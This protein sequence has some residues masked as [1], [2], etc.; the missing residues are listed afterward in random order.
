MKALMYVSNCILPLLFFLVIGA[1]L[2]RRVAVYDEF[3]KGA[4]EGFT[5]VLS[6]LPTLVG[7]MM[8]VGIL[9]A[10][11]A[12]TAI[13]RVLSPIA[14]LLHFPEELI[15]LSLVRMFSSSAATGLAL[16]IF[17]QYGPDSF[18]GVATSLLLSSTET[19]FYT[20]SVYCL[21]AKV[22]KTRWTLSGALTA[23]FCGMAISIILAGFTLF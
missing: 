2:I 15:P 22:T 11:G 19:I 17:E 7:L 13:G 9:R 21:T 3:V 8:G 20:L 18:L 4:K 14:R 16:D 6:I 23:T 12:L 1:G 5:T 10:S